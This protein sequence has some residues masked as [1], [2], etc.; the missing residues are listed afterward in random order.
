MLLI[1]WWK[2]KV[3]KTSQWTNLRV[4]KLIPRLG[5]LT[6]KLLKISKLWELIWVKLKATGLQLPNHLKKGI[7]ALELQPDHLS[8]CQNHHLSNKLL[9]TKTFHGMRSRLTKNTTTRSQ[10]SPCSALLPPSKSKKAIQCSPSWW[11]LRRFHPICK[12]CLNPRETPISWLNEACTRYPRL[13]P[14][15]PWL[16]PRAA[17]NSSRRITGGTGILTRGT[18]GSR[19]EVVSTS[20]DFFI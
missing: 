1:T 10:S 11:N 16:V 8:N 15:Q 6:K 18:R 2:L 12:R 5:L 14:T 7:P 20:T 17:L 13:S 3:V 19:G 9:L 4:R